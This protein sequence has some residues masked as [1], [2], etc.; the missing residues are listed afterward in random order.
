MLGQLAILHWT[1]QST[2]LRKS[3]NRMYSVGAL[4]EARAAFQMCT[5]MIKYDRDQNHSMNV[6]SQFAN[7]PMSVIPFPKINA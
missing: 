1:P 2:G 5:W 7:A 3:R 4:D 6:G